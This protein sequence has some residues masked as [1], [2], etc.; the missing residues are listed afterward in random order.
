MAAVVVYH[1]QQS[2]KEI[3]PIIRNITL[4]TPKGHT[5]K[6]TLPADTELVLP[7]TVCTVTT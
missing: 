6:Y 5:E 1:Q 4:H 7:T 2:G 3:E